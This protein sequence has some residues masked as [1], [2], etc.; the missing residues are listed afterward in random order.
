MIVYAQHKN[1]LTQQ[2]DTLVFRTLTE[3]TNFFDVLLD[4]DSI[5]KKLKRKKYCHIYASPDVSL[6]IGYT[7]TW[8]LTKERE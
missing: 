5:Q 1:P 4:Y 3:A 8:L 7:G 2:C 6:P